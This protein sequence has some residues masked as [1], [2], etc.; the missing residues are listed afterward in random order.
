MSNP[1]GSFAIAFLQ[2][3]NPGNPTFFRVRAGDVGL[4]AQNG[5]SIIDGFS[6]ELLITTKGPDTVLK[7]IVDPNG[8][9]FFLAGPVIKAA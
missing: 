8:V 9:L 7:M 1:P 4:S 3:A 2:L 6:G 5:Y